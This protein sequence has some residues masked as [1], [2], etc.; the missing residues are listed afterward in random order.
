MSS[1]EVT[2]KVPVDVNDLQ[3][4][5]I[6]EKRSLKSPAVYTWGSNVYRVVDP[7]SKDTDIKTPRRF[8]YFDG[9]VLRDL[10]IEEKSGAAITENG[11]LVQW[12]KAYSESDFKP[13]VTLTG[14]NLTSLVL[15]ES[16][17]IALSSDGTVYSL[18]IS[19]DG[20]RT[21]PKTT[22]SSWVPF[23]PNQSN[24]SYR[25]LSPSLKLGCFSQALAESSLRRHPPK[26]TLR[27]AN[28]VWRDLPGPPDPKGQQMPVMK[29]QLS[30]ALRLF[31]LLVV[32]TTR[33]R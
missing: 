10:K 2:K 32:I 30:K 26:T 1:P 9:Q 14:K 7:G 22:E 6:Q 4:Q 16:R 31:R 12:G 18:P 25:V 17:I 33:W 19:K 13:T 27:L 15:S 8:K 20:Q 3:A 28:S 24:L 29:L 21:G 23:W 11:D 5:F